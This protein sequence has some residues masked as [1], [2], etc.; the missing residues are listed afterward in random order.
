[1]D[2]ISVELAGELWGPVL[3]RAMA[4]GE[5]RHDLNLNDAAAWLATVM[6]MLIGEDEQSE[7]AT[8]DIRRMLR[9]FLVPAFIA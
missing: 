4:R 7:T 5:A 6:F 2:K 8:Q 9:S 1:M 3:L